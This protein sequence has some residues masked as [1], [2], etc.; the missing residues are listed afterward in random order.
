[1]KVPDAFEVEVRSLELRF[2]IPVAS[3]DGTTEEWSEVK[4]LKNEVATAKSIKKVTF[5]QDANELQ[6]R[7]IVEASAS[8]EDELLTKVFLELWDTIRK[9]KLLQEGLCETPPSWQV[10]KDGD[11]VADEGFFREPEPSTS[12]A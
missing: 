12:D 1:M 4:T 11:F 7:C 2:I 5:A 10:I 8:S 9:S 3:L 6:L